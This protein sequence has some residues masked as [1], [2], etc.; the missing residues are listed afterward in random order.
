MLCL[1][2]YT[3]VFIGHCFLF[4]QFYFFFFLL[5]KNIFKPLTVNILIRYSK[6]S[7]PIIILCN[8]FIAWGEQEPKEHP[9]G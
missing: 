5:L 4:K 7:K 1:F 6:V 8:P 3:V 9:E 2:I